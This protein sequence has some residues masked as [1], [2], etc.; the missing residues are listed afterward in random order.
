MNYEVRIGTSPS[1]PRDIAG[2]RT[3]AA[4]AKGGAQS[5]IR[6]IRT[7]P[8]PRTTHQ[9]RPQSLYAGTVHS[10]CQC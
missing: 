9:R 1:L 4:S 10:Q 7:R 6:Y 5:S 2:E 8:P 3:D